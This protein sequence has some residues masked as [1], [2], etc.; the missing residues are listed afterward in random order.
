[1]K[2]KLIAAAVV[3]AFAAPAAFAAS[4]V[5]IYGTFNAEYGFVSAP[6][7]VPGAP[8]RN[9]FD[10]FD[11]GASNIGIKAEEKLS[12][13]M[14]AF[15]QCES[16][17]RFLSG[18]GRTSGSLCDRISAI[19]L[20]GGFGSFFLGTWDSP[21]K[22]AVGK[23]R[24]LADT[25]F[26]GVTH[27]TF[28]AFS[29]RNVQSINYHSPNFSGFSFMAQTTSTNPAN[30]TAVPG[31][32]GRLTSLGGYYDRGPL[33]VAAGWTKADDNRAVNIT[34]PLGA[35]GSEDTGVSAGVTYKFGPAKVGFTWYDESFEEPTTV[36]DLERNAYNL[37]LHWSLG[38][39][40]S[41]LAGYTV[42]EDI[43]GIAAGV[44]VVGNNGAKE[45]QISFIH[46]LSKRT[47]TAIGYARLKNDGGGALYAVGNRTSI[48][49]QGLGGK[50]S[51]VTVQLKHRF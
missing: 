25:G 2:Q 4:T 35:V 10:G 28:A 41:I 40:N 12:G 31:R 51:V 6:D 32:K 23:T 50:S 16:D 9:N 48:T 29:N 24:M 45:Y 21:Q 18:A 17:I 43:E 34:A 26:L 49:G 14:S 5:Q 39:P 27:M 37:A 42:A 33:T 20:K 19:G 8:G 36:T 7:A 3:G 22:L 44:P 30:G 11:S 13:G 46:M 1:M 47:T 38:G 15:V